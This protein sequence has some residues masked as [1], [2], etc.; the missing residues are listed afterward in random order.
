[1]S[2]I[3]AT[4]AVNPALRAAPETPPVAGPASDLSFGDL[5]MRGVSHVDAQVSGADDLMRQFALDGDAVPIHQVTLAL[6]EA[7]YAVDLAMQVRA[8]LVE[9]YRDLMNMQL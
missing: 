6:A 5:L 7:Q 2:A 9:G 3:E 1:M 8:R 4:S